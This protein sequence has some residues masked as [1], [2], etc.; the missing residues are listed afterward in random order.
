MPT[1]KVS[2]VQVI[3]SLAEITR[4]QDREVLEKSLVTTL[5]ELIPA[6]EFRLYKVQVAGDSLE[7]ALSAFAAKGAVVSEALP[8]NHKIP[9]GLAQGILKAVRSETLVQHE[10]A[11]K[12][13]YNIIYPVYDRYDEIYGV[14]V[15]VTTSPSYEDQRFTHG[16]LRVYSN[17]LALLEESQKDKLTNL[18]NRETLDREITKLIVGNARKA[19]QSSDDS[20]RSTDVWKAWLCVVDVDH[21]KRV[22]DRFGHLFGDEVLI[23]LARLL[24]STFR[25][26]DQTFRYGGEEFVI[27]FKTLDRRDAVSVCER[28]R[29]TVE[30]HVFP[31]V[32]KVTISVG[33]VQITNQEGTAGVIDQADK[34]LYF[35]KEHGRNQ[36][37]FYSDME[38]SAPLV[39]EPDGEANSLDYF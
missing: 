2:T 3:D 31:Q 34:A 7:M 33:V 8:R 9:E 12:R 26:D 13:L 23:L 30:S 10:D 25:Q 22:N 39:L 35:A 37:C 36:V 24:E 21:F 27:V 14:M 17:Y 11:E 18:L 15:Q 32:G 6:L 1:K 29:K 19:Y 28:L 16:L 5:S 20:R 4:Y 38:Q